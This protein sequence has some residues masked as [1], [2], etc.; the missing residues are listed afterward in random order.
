MQIVKRSELRDLFLRIQHATML[1]ITAETIPALRKSSDLG[2]V[3]P[4]WDDYK[5]GRFVKVAQ[6]NGVAYWVYRNSVLRKR[7]K[8]GVE[9]EWE[10]APRQWGVR[11]AGT[12]FVEH[13]NKAGEFHT[14]LEL[15]VERSLGYIYRLNGKEIGSDHIHPFLRPASPNRQ[16]LSDEDEVLVRDYDLDN[17]LEVR[18]TLPGDQPGEIYT[19]VED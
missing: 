17:I 11:V 19:V 10:P 9:G 4:F 5:A 7:D 8:V 12:P 13:T 2:V 1:T 16:G 18:V 14:Y 15:K 3:C 6:T